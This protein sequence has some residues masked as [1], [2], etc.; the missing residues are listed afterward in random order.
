MAGKTNKVERIW[1]D[2][3]MPGEKRAT[4]LPA[5]I[6]LGAG[7]SDETKDAIIHIDVLRRRERL[8]TTIVL[9]SSYTI[10]YII[11][12]TLPE[13]TPSDI[14]SFFILATVFTTAAEIARYYKIF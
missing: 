13:V 1:N 10:S 14:T 9:S 11:L 2:P 5:D 4:A 12:T 7:V 3:P 8:I 6:T